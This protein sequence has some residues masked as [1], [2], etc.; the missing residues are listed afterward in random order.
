MKIIINGKTSEYDRQPTIAE[1]VNDIGA[2]QKRAA[3][4]LNEDIVKRTEWINTQLK[5]GDSIEILVLAGGG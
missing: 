1:V 3:V 5:D 4:I 2:D